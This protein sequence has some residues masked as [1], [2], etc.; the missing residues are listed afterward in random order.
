MVPSV[1]RCLFCIPQI[2]SWMTFGANTP[3]VLSNDVGPIC[4]EHMNAIMKDRFGDVT[5]QVA[6]KNRKAD[7]MY[8]KNDFGQTPQLLFGA[9]NLLTT[10]PQKTQ[11]KHR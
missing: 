11:P 10:S 5:L 1:A 7:A 4:L 9:L 3:K 8:Q 6:I 2:L